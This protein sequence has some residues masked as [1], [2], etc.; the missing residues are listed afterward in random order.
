MENSSAGQ[1][2]TTLDNHQHHHP[3][4]PLILTFLI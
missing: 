1:V 3:Q 4:M 2:I